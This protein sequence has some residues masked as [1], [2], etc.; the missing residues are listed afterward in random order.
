VEQQGRQAG[1]ANGDPGQWLVVFRCVK[2]PL[3]LLYLEE[4]ISGKLATTL[5]SPIWCLWGDE[6]VMERLPGEFEVIVTG[7]LRTSSVRTGVKPA[8]A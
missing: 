5:D 3:H 4:G 6:A 7:A 8:S 2:N 1:W